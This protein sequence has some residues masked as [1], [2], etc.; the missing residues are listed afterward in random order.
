MSRDDRRIELLAQWLVDT[1]RRKGLSAA[2]WA[3]AAGHADT[4]ISRFLKQRSHLLRKETVENLAAA[5][6]VP[7]PDLDDAHVPP[8]PLL[9]AT[10]RLHSLMAQRQ[11]LWAELMHLD[12]MIAQQLAELQVT[13][14]RHAVAPDPVEAPRPVMH[15]AAAE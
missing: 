14:R 7:P 8:V 3:H 12:E 11:R 5:A 13:H 4:T 15:P 6:G 10:A 1:M 9:E 2:G